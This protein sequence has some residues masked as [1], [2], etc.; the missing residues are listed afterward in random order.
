M[1]IGWRWLLEDTDKLIIFHD[2][3]LPKYRDLHH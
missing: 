2:S 1:A 3:L